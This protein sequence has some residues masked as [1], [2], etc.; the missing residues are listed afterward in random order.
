MG[1]DSAIKKEWVANTC[2]RV[3]EVYMPYLNERNH[4]QKHMYVLYVSIYMR[5]RESRLVATRGW[6]F[7]VSWLQRLRGK[8]LERQKCSISWTLWWWLHDSDYLSTLVELQ[9]WLPGWLSF[10]RSCIHHR[11]HDRNSFVRGRKNEWIRYREISTGDLATSIHIKLFA[12][13]FTLWLWR[14]GKVNSCIQEFSS[15]L[16]SWDICLLD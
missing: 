2:N 12:V 13:S 1:Y 3:S 9:P 7:S 8:F 6:G 15:W 10:S 5:S 11:N 4:F 16:G 14:L